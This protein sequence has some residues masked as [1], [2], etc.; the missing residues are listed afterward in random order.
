VAM[1]VSKGRLGLDRDVADWVTRALAF[2][3]VSLEALS[4]A[5]SV[6]STRLPGDLHGDPADRLIA[7]TALHF[8]APLVTKDT[9]LRA[10]GQVETIW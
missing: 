2:P 10:W 3:K 1:L 5:I 8:G 4:P 6:L 7:A 9:A